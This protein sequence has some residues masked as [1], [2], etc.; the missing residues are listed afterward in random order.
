MIVTITT[1]E[2]LR[3]QLQDMEPGAPFALVNT[4]H[5]VFT[6]VTRI[7]DLREGNLHPVAGFA[8]PSDGCL[9]VVALGGQ[10]GRVVSPGTILRVRGDDQVIPL[11]AV[12]PVN[13]I[14]VESTR[15]EN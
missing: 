5:I 2:R 8:S 14:E 6:R 3:P 13:F 15:K 1:S 4:P 11:R 9:T 7:A 12:E 10:H